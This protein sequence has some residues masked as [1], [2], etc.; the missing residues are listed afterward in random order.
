MPTRAQ[1][2]RYHHLAFDV[3]FHGATGPEGHRLRFSRVERGLLCAL[4]ARPGQLFSR[5]QL[6]GAMTS[7]PEALSDPYVDFV[8]NRLRRKLGDPARAPRF[9]ATE[10]GEGYAWIAPAARAGRTGFLV[11]GPLRGLPEPASRASIEK[12]VA[13][14]AGKIAERCAKGRDVVFL[15]AWSRIDGAEDAFR[16]SVGVD[17]IAGRGA[18]Q[19]AFTLR[20][21]IDGRLV[22]VVRCDLAEP[23]RDRRLGEAADSLVGAIW[24]DL[25]L[26]PACGLDPGGPPLEIRMQ[27]A[28]M[29]LSPSL[30]RGWGYIAERLADEEA[31]SPQDPQLAILRATHL[32]AGMLL[33]LD[34]GSDP[35]RFAAAERQIERLTLAAL[36]AVR[37]DPIFRLAAA[38]LL[39]AVDKA[40]LALVEALVEETLAEST[41][42]AAALCQ[43]GTVQ[44]WRGDLAAA[45]G[46][47]DEA[48]TF[49]QPGSE[50]QIYLLVKRSAALVARGDWMAAQA[51]L[52]RIGELKPAARGRLEVFYL[53]PDDAPISSEARAALDSF[54][55]SAATRLL[56]R[57]YHLFARHFSRAEHARNLMAGPAWHLAARLG[58]SV[59]PDVVRRMDLPAQRAE[60]TQA[61]G[62]RPRATS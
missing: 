33:N 28:A 58:P 49:C 16:F 38:K 60:L 3:D 59:L 57:H 14:L 43:Q 6:L 39:F 54:S 2:L 51:L 19:A 22:R 40:R 12:V 8:I 29:A 5:E 7:D 11:V 34:F 48:L 55:K 32:Y 50:F 15:P 31:A 36:P 45:I 21:E 20:N 26:A 61:P 37:G 30:A 4:A 25:T 46:S 56:W 13:G 44:A 24:R 62:S 17:L 1:P 52:R 47:F 18:A 53:S 41:A 9:I 27:E 42:F 23:E 10:Y 35:E